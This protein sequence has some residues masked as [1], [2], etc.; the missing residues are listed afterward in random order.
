[1]GAATTSSLERARM[2]SGSA[3]KSYAGSWGNGEAR[4][5]KRPHGSE[6]SDERP[7][8]TGFWVTAAQASRFGTLFSSVCSKPFET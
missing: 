5:T 4:R 2:T 7:A 1:M 8:L 3:G 6:T